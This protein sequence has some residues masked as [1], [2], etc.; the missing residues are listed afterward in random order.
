MA[1]LQHLPVLQGT[2][3]RLE[4]LEQAHIP[5]LVALGR[6]ERIWSLMSVDGSKGNFLE[7]HLKSAILKKAVGEQ[8]PYT[9]YDRATGALI[10]STMLYNLSPEHR[11]LEI[12]WTWYAPEW[13]QTG[14]NR[15]CKLL[16]LTLCFETLKTIRVQLTTDVNNFRSRKAIEGIGAVME[17]ILRNER[18][19]A[20]GA[21][22]DSVIYSIIVQEWP[23]V[24]Q[25]LEHAI[26]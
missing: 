21:Y 15:E 16:L 11:K 24:K 6:D 8:F 19:R 5:A 12:G 26:R 9:V 20:N 10:G 17:G 14:H 1:W 3:V 22:R 23:E 2:K 18:I 4:P 7:T 13:W 25:K